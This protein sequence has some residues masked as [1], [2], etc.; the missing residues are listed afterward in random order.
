M[1]YSGKEDTLKPTDT[2]VNGES[3]VINRIASYVKEWSGNWDA[4]WENIR[5]R[6]KIKDTLVKLSDKL[7]M[8]ELVEAEWVTLSNSQY[9]LVV[10]RL[11]EETGAA[12]PKIVYEEWEKWLRER[13]RSRKPV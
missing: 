3:E 11:R 6:A 2:L 12:G 10:E 1:E 4:V 8:P 9:H 5:L 13:I 7:K